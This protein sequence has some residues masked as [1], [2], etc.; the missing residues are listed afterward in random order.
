MIVVDVFCN[1]FVV[2][3]LALYWGLLCKFF[4]YLNCISTVEKFVKSLYLYA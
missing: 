1:A 3:S 2:S 4:T